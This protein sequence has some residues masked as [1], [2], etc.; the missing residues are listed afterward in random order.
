MG[1]DLPCPWELDSSTVGVLLDSVIPR[2]LSLPTI[3][4]IDDITKRDQYTVIIV[5]NL[6]AEWQERLRSQLKIGQ[7]FF[8]RH[9]HGRPQSDD[10]YTE[11]F[12]LTA[13][14]RRR[15]DS[16]QWYAELSEDLYR[17]NREPC[18]WHGD[19]ILTL[20]GTHNKMHSIA[21]QATS[22]IRRRL[23]HHPQFGWHTST[24]VSVLRLRNLC[25]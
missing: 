18:Y 17:P 9:N 7:I 5:Q 20:E 10:L 6:D 21:H 4:S 1:P 22:P 2:R 11:I 16:G 24:R 19:G 15:P 23:T 3:P 12:G 8:D 25:E 14:Q 13:Y